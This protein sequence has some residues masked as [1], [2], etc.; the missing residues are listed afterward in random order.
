MD[1]ETLLAFI[2]RILSNG[3]TQKSTIAL[4]QLQQILKAQNADPT[5]IDLISMT[6]NGM[7]EARAAAKD[8]PLTEE[9]LRIALQRARIRREREIANA[10]RGRC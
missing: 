7:P 8:D 9:A 1:K 2:Q 6:L 3:S 4:Q 5:L 10:N